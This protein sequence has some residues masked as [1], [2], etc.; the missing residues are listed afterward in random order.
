[1]RQHDDEFAALLSDGCLR[2]GEDALLCG[3][4]HLVLPGEGKSQ[5]A[6]ALLGL[7]SWRQ[8]AGDYVGSDGAGLDTASRESGGND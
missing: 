7:V 4:H 6:A 3:D 5:R 8:R 1:L 2:V